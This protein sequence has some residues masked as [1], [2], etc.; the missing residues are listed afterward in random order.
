MTIALTTIFRSLAPVPQAPGNADMEGTASG[1]IAA[2]VIP[3]HTGDEH[4]TG[5]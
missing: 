2:A 4:V 1:V 5:K 3:A